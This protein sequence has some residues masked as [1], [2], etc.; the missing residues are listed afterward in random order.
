M[1]IP[2]SQSTDIPKGSYIQ[3]TDPNLV[4]GNYVSAGKFWVDTSVSPPLL[5][6]RNVTNTSWI[7]INNTGM[8]QS[9]YDP[10]G[11]NDDA[12]DR[13]NHTGTQPESSIVNLV[14][15]LAGK[16]STS[17]TH[18][19]SNVTDFSSAV[20]ANSDV[21][22]NTT[23]RHTHSNISLLN[24]LETGG[25]GTGYLDNQGNYT[26][27]A[28]GGG[29]GG[30]TNLGSNIGTAGV[31]IFKDKSGVT[32]RF[33]K[34]NAGSNKVTITDD[35]GNNEVDIDVA[36]SNLTIGQSQVTSLVSDLA[37]KA[38][39]AS[40]TFT[41]T[42]AG[43]TKTM[44]GLGNVDNTSDSTKNSATVALTNK[45][46]NGSNNTITNLGT[47]T[48]SDGAVTPIKLSSAVTLSDAGTVA[49]DF[50]LGKE[51][52][53]ASSNSRTIGIPTNPVDWKT[54]TLIF[55]NVSG[56]SQTLSLTTGSSGAFYY[57][58]DVP[59]LTATPAGTFDAIVAM[60]N[61]IRARWDLLA[62]SKLG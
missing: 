7:Q 40:P 2:L 37:A 36:E 25:D 43:I 61:P 58:A 28:G 17:H 51:F 29:G 31:G 26:V 42:V 56:S 21:T 15:D 11:I 3:N 34:L 49:V 23:A 45:T 52:Y 48:L 62:Y 55:K 54:M 5:K 38:P 60:Y 41:G 12:F 24:S 33:K 27:P 8:A 22:A 16:A 53:L 47:S 19:A 20:S 59:A 44:V 1:S 4:V 39:I 14:S 9:I 18:T 57:T 6:V 32:L 30:E 13:A 50:S 10:Q 35:T 46:I